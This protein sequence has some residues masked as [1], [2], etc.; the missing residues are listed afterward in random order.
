VKAARP[1]RAP[2]CLA[3]RERE[4]F[5]TRR[6]EPGL[7]GPAVRAVRAQPAPPLQRQLRAQV[8]GQRPAQGQVRRA[9]PRRDHRPRDRRAAGRGHRGPAAGGAPLLLLAAELASV[10]DVLCAPATGWRWARTLRTCSWRRGLPL[11]A[12]LASAGD[13]LCAPAWPPAGGEARTRLLSCSSSFSSACDPEDGLA[14][15]VPSW[16]AVRTDPCTARAASTDSHSHRELPACSGGASARRTAAAATP[17]AQP[18]G[19]AAAC[20]EGLRRTIVLKEEIGGNGPPRLEGKRD[21]VVVDS[22]RL[23]PGRSNEV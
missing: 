16:A 5:H 17:G 13:V 10:G 22:H 14:G 1:G 4:E 9:D 3:A 21:K 6:Q 19:R 12:E 11:A 7:P 20:S 18:G 2:V 23:T 15:A 8:P